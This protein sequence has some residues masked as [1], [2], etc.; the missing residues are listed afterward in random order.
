MSPI[1]YVI[2]LIVIVLLLSLIFLYNFYYKKNKY[3]ALFALG[4]RNENNGCY[5]EALQNYND[6]L[7]ALSTQKFNEQLKIKTV[8]RIKLLRFTIEY[9]SLKKGLYK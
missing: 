8:E 5:T 1:L 9:D 6:V 7:Q 3:T 4:L 2:T